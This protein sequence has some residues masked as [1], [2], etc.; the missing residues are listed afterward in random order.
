M[1]I[2]GTRV[3]N[4][5]R[6]KTMTVPFV[7]NDVWCSVSKLNNLTGLIHC[8]T[9][10]RRRSASLGLQKWK[11]WRGWGCDSCNKKRHLFLLLLFRLVSSKDDIY[12]TLFTGIKLIG[13]PEKWCPV[14]QAVIIYI[15]SKTPQSPLP[16]YPPQAV[17]FTRKV[18]LENNRSTDLTIIPYSRFKRRERQYGVFLQNMKYSSFVEPLGTNKQQLF[19]K[20]NM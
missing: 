6:P 14:C 3:R 17:K 10:T 18:I 2:K 4:L 1:C 13:P 20:S 11:E 19:P 8:N 5:F 12:S 15:N 9:W 16:Q 7:L